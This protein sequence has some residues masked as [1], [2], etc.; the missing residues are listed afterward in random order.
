MA[1]AQQS[2]R[3]ILRSK[4]SLV[5]KEATYEQTKGNFLPYFGVNLTDIVSNNPL[6]VF[7]FKLLH[8]DACQEGF[9]PALLNSPDVINHYNL[10][11]NAM[12]PLYNPEAKAEHKADKHQIK[13]S[14]SMAQQTS[15]AIEL[16]VI[17]S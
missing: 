5:V 9:N 16:E 8:E 2:N 17:K 11:L 1:I 7:G 10:S 4:Q 15:E 6:N 14:E 3:S 13:M 12:M